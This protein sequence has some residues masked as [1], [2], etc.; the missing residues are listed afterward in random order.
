VLHFA[1]C[2]SLLYSKRAV[3]ASVRHHGW[4]ASQEVRQQYHDP[5]VI[6]PSAA[7]LPNLEQLKAFTQAL[8]QCLAQHTDR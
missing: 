3:E 4:G 6:L 7:H 1:P 5:W 8:T 2:I